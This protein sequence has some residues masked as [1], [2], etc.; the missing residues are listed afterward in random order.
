MLRG[1][2]LRRCML[3]R[4]MLV[5]FFLRFWLRLETRSRWVGSEFS[6]HW[7][8]FPRHW[9]AVNSLCSSWFSR[10]GFWWSDFYALFQLE[11]GSTVCWFHFLSF[12]IFVFS[13]RCTFHH[14]SRLLWFSLSPYLLLQVWIVFFSVYALHAWKVVYGLKLKLWFLGGWLPFSHTKVVYI[15]LMHPLV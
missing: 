2:F 4:S 14:W 13:S 8:Y 9:F 3:F 10:S 1:C 12:Y 6:C 15:L 5:L 11:D 7:C